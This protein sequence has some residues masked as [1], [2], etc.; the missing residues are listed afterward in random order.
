MIRLID[1]FVCLFIYLFIRDVVH[2]TNALCFL[3]ALK[4]MGEQNETCQKYTSML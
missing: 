2:V 1:L 4:E 3:V